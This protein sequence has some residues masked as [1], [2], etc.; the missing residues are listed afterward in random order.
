MSTAPQTALLFAGQ[1]SQAVGM[2][3]ALYDNFPEARAVFERA[4]EALGEPLSQLIFEGPEADLLRTA[5]AQP[6]IL[7]VSV[8]AWAILQARG[9]Q[10]TVLAGHSLGE[11][12]ALVAAGALRFEDAL[13]LVRQR[14]EFMQRAVPEGEGAMAAI[15]RVEEAQV[16]AICAQAPGLCVPALYNAPGLVVISGEREAVLWASAQLAD[17]GAFVT[18][19]AV[20]AP[21]HCRLLEPAAQALSALLDA[22]AFDPLQIP[23]VRNVDAQWVEEC[24]PA[25]IRESLVRQVVQPVRWR[26]GLTLMRERGVTRFW[27][28]GPGRANLSHV[29]RIDRKAQLASFDS[30]RELEAILSALSDPEDNP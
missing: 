21:F 17:A 25:Q 4:D 30:P 11:Y 12:S 3:R 5:N 29:K 10:P 24:A 13:T 16:E 28:L 6:A 15:Q 8:A 18:P 23:Y 19:L 7:T 20:S 22:T 1:A 2:G 14:G 26:E 27:H 9:F